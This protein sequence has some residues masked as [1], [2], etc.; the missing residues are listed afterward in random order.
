TGGYNAGD[1][2]DL[3]H[4]YDIWQ[5]SADWYVAPQVRVGAL[6]GV[7]EDTSGRNQGASGGSIGAYYDLSKRT[8]LYALADTIHNETNGGFRPAGSAGLKANF[9]NP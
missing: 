6:W 3:H 8:T 1:N 5:V 2:P 4:F 9:T 7:I